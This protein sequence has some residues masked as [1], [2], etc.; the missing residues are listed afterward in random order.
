M[1]GARELGC[2]A[3]ALSNRSR[4]M[5]AHLRRQP[6]GN[7]D[8]FRQLNEISGTHHFSSRLPVHAECSTWRLE[9]SLVAKAC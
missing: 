7:G 4:V 3:I 8:I 6:F 2:M 5:P 9:Q 1:V